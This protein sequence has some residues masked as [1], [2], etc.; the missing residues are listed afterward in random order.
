MNAGRVKG[1]TVQAA[2]WASVGAYNNRNKKS[3]LLQGFKL[4]GAFFGE[5]LVNRFANKKFAA[6]QQVS[7]ASFQWYY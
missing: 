4:Q 7:L 6:R 1:W 3:K 5:S 2:L